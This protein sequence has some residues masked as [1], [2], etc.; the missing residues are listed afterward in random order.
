M[1]GANTLI[2]CIATRS[3]PHH[4]LFFGEREVFLRV[5]VARAARTPQT[6]LQ[7]NTVALI[8]V[9]ELHAGL[10]KGTGRGCVVVHLVVG[11]HLD[12]LFWWDCMRKGVQLVGGSV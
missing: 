2:I 4:L 12:G 8:G 11:G 6:A 3:Q 10:Y 7:R 9:V 5:V 1:V